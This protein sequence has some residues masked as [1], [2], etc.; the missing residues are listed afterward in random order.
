M[1]KGQPTAPLPVMG[2]VRRGLGLWSEKAVSLW[3][4]L[5]PLIVATQL[6][7]VLATVSAAPAGSFAQNGTIYILPGSS[8][9]GL[10]AAHLLFVLL[11][12]LVGVLCA[13]VSLRIFSEAAQGHGEPPRAALGFVARRFGGLLW[14]SLLV[15]VVVA[16]G[17]IALVVPG[18]WAMV[19]LS[20]ALVVFV[21]EGVGGFAALRR[22]RDLVRGRW[23]PTFGATLP[24]ALSIAAGAFLIDTTTAVSG[25]IAK[26][27]IARAV[28]SLAIQAV[29][30]PIGTATSVAIYH[31][32]LTR[33]QG[34]HAV[35]SV[36][37][38]PAPVAAPPGSPGDIWWS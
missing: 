20:V 27:A 2:V 13:G 8:T 24:S 15:G 25:G 38:A 32:L 3:S 17:F 28:G 35:P 30:V 11:L 33:T 34:G 19:A 21:V 1:P 37:A 7:G 16:G 36:A 4:V 14:V 12:T 10:N 26:L 6:V 5:V 22:S 31:D 18:V 9:S 29:L 23:W